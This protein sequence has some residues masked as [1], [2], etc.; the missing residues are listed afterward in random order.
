M[1]K[2]VLRISSIAGACVLLGAIIAVAGEKPPADAIPLSEIVKSIEAKGYAPIV[3]VSI[4]DGVWEAEAYKG[5]EKRE[6]KV[7][8]LSG[9]I[10]SDRPDK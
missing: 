7:D 9:D 2:S 4:D 5:A 6:L 10:I 8:P 1:N 3:E